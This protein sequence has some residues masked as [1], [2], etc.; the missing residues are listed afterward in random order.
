MDFGGSQKW[1]MDVLPRHVG[2]AIADSHGQTWAVRSRVIAC[3]CWYRANAG[4]GARSSNGQNALFS[5]HYGWA[6]R[7]GDPMDG[8]RPF[9]KL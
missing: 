2:A 1:P 3:C 7:T 4:N 6:N 9:Q 5:S 8:L